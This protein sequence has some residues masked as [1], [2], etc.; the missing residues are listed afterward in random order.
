MKISHVGTCNTG[1]AGDIALYHLTQ[2]LFEKFLG[3]QKF[4]NINIHKLITAKEVA[5]FNAAEFVLIGGGGVF[6]KDTK[7][8]ANSGWFWN[9]PLPCLCKIKS[10]LI[11]FGVGYNRFRGQEEFDPIF[12]KHINAITRRAVFFGLRNNGSVGKIKGYLNKN[13]KFHERLCMQPCPTTLLAKFYKTKKVKKRKVMAVNIAEDRKALRKVGIKL[14]NSVVNVAK[15]AIKKGF[16]IEIVSHCPADRDEIV[17]IFKKNK[18]KHKIVKLEYA[19]VGT[20]IRYY[21]SISLAIGMRGHSQMIPFGVSTP[22]YSLISHDKLRY[23]LN[24]INC[25]WG[26]EI[27]DANLESKIISH[28][29]LVVE[30]PKSIVSK[31][32]NERNRLWSITQ[33]NFV[34]IKELLNA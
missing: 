14:Y 11:V 32:N 29:D 12:R 28:I 3:R 26:A 13:E 31:I 20:I 24:D 30:N 6:L 34:K 8:N 9:C 18:V 5:T 33:A 2:K 21:K 22:F 25:S 1:N 17:D 10:P 16:A 7:A 19:K 4:S 23:F 15:Y 27:S